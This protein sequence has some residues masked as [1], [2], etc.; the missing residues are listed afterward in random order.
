MR[1]IFTIPRLFSQSA[2]FA[3]S[4]SKFP[5]RVRTLALSITD[6][7]ST[8]RLASVFRSAAQSI[9]ETLSGISQAI[10]PR[11]FTQSAT[12]SS[13]TSRL[14]ASIRTIGQ[15]ITESFSANRLL[16][17]IRPFTQS[18]TAAFTESPLRISFRTLAQAITD[19]FSASRLL[20]VP[21]TLGLSLT[22]SFATS[23][24]FQFVRTLGQSITETFS[25]NRLAS[26][27]RSA[28]QSITDTFS[29]RNIFT[30]PRLFSQAVTGNFIAKQVSTFSRSVSQSISEA[31]SASRLALV[32]RSVTQSITDTFSTSRFLTIPRSLTQ[33]FTGSFV[34][35]EQF[36]FVR[37]FAQ[38]I[39]QTLVPSRLLS[40]SQT[41]SQQLTGT[42]SLSKLGIISRTLTNSFTLGNAISQTRSV[43]RTLQQSLSVSSA[44]SRAVL[45]IRSVTGS[46]A[47]GNNGILPFQSY[48]VTISQAFNAFFSAVAQVIAGTSGGSS[49]QDS[50]SGSSGGGGGVSA[51][52][53]EI[54]PDEPITPSSTTGFVVLQ[55]S[56]LT[57]V[58]PTE[59][60]TNGITIKNVLGKP[61]TNAKVAVTG[62]PAG[63]VTVPQPVSIAAGATATM[64]A[65]IAV[66][67]D[68][69]SGD[70]AVVLS[71]QEQG[72]S[73]TSEFVLRV[74][75][76][77]PE[78]D[79]AIT[80]RHVGVGQDSGSSI[81]LRILNGNEKIP[82]YDII[83]VIDKSIASSVDEIEFS[84]PPTEIIQA[85]PIVKWTLHDLVPGESRNVSYQTKH[86][87][88]EFTPY[89]YWPVDEIALSIVSLPEIAISLLRAI[90]IVPG[91]SAQ[92]V[93]TLQNSEASEAN[94]TLELNLP[95]GWRTEPGFI[96]DTLLPGAAKTY[97]FQVTA[98]ADLAPG[99]YT[100]NLVM[101]LN[102]GVIIKQ[103][104][105]AALNPL[106]Y[107][108]RALQQPSA[109]VFITL[110]SLS[111]AWIAVRAVRK[112]KKRSVWSRLLLRN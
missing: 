92:A 103:Y 91:G 26:V 2:T 82:N 24:Q 1:N 64:I 79:K 18:L 107:L 41:I 85:D 22:G 100:G 75:S 6:S 109:L 49:S 44:T 59:V 25:A 31:F 8:S 20:T 101:T 86:V 52:T 45:A 56:V 78:T 10:F 108:N 74:R 111:I 11:S 99:Y 57:E 68:A 71:L 33:S 19:T 36:G 98:P 112:R 12:L 73:G 5:V 9:T 89:V 72:F 84:V 38:S 55:Q 105:F 30:I 21:R 13:S 90:E 87:L 83:E 67:E 50:G 35:G 40:V 61:I 53:G 28:T 60:V 37:S 70:Y 32:F 63:W 93:V 66:P 39:S 15:S 106:A 43:I 58:L 16:S 23:D 97:G 88:T 102:G 110:V 81:L 62:V 77:D 96:Q 29:V 7:F 46:L 51:P 54:I 17:L 34:S 80:L 14:L 4:V 69:A 48:F 104:Q 42:F 3:S 76:F 47:V 65:V 27:F 94:V 95:D